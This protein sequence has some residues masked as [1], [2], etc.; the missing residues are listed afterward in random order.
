MLELCSAFGQRVRERRQKL[1]KSIE[2]LA[3]EC[4]LTA[5]YVGGI[6]RGKRNP[7]LETVCRLAYALRIKASELL[8]DLAWVPSEDQLT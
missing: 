1:G 6:E 4:G 8:E 7:T 2:K 5:N 3:S